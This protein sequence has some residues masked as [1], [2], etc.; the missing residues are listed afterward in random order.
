MLSALSDEA[1]QSPAFRIL[2]P[3][4]SGLPGGPLESAIAF[5]GANAR[6]TGKEPFGLR[7]QAARIQRD[8][9]VRWAEESGLIVE[10]S[11]WLG[12]A[13]LGGS[14]HE[15]W[16]VEE[17]IWKVTHPDR[18]GWTVL[19]GSEGKPEIAEA[20]PLE[21]LER[22]LTAN[23]LLGDSAR[24]RGVSHSEGEVRIVISQPFIEGPYP[25]K[26]AIVMELRRRGFLLVP[27]FFIGSE[28]DS[29][30]YHEREGIAIFDATC[31]N[32]I[33]SHGLPIP[34]DVVVVPVGGLLHLQLVRLM[35]RN[36]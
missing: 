13:V 12:K 7:Q 10:P 36:S 6:T 3:H 30:F 24:L 26:A 9:I 18:F 17:E 11:L 8:A 23:R 29:S 2:G 4:V 33:L 20:T 22:W 25:E 28:A 21:Y 16:E 14:E 19:P 35:G 5:V 27:H 1:A 34:V 31:D 15:I 32:F